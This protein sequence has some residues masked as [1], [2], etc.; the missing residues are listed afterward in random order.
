MNGTSINQ[1]SNKLNS[2]I[3]KVGIWLVA[4]KLTLNTT[5]TEFM[6]I[7][8]RHNLAKIKKD[9]II[10]IREKKIQRVR[11]TKSLGVIAES[12]ELCR[13]L[14]LTTE[15]STYER[16]GDCIFTIPLLISSFIS[17]YNLSQ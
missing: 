8:S 5:K 4:N 11:K 14:V 17:I 12:H 1:I 6:I 3:N 2:E 15:Q 9:P 7:G 13:S 16:S 10:S